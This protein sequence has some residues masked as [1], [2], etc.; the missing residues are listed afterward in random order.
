MQADTVGDELHH[1]DGSHRITPPTADGSALERH[2]RKLRAHLA[3]GHEHDATLPADELLA[4][5]GVAGVR[6]AER[7]GP[8]VGLLG[9]VR[10]LLYGDKP[11]EPPNAWGD[12]AANRLR[13][14]QPVLTRLWAELVALEVA[15]VPPTTDEEADHG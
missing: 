10:K 8:A 15:L 3:D 6:P 14:A 1:P 13:A 5:H 7:I 2:E 4:E 12:E 9:H 11:T